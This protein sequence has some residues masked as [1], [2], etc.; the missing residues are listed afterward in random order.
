VLLHLAD[1][2]ALLAAVDRDR[3]V[4]LGH[5]VGEHGL[6]HDALNLLDAAHVLLL[7]CSF[8]VRSFAG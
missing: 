8:Q 1:Q 3:V 5:V 7:R 4:D 2:Q 6:D